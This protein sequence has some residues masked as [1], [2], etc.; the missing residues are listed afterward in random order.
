[1]HRQKCT[2]KRRK[3]E[4]AFIIGMRC[5]AVTHLHLLFISSS[6]QKWID[7]WGSS[8]SLSLAKVNNSKLKWI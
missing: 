5:G 8:S 2:R 7:T 1:M 4:L 6:D 3:N